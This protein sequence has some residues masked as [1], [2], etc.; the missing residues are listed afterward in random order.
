MGLSLCMNAGGGGDDVR[1]D[2][3]AFQVSCDIS[4]MDEIDEYCW[5]EFGPKDW[6]RS[7]MFYNFRNKEDSVQFR[8][9]F[10]G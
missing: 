1:D 6:F 2:W 10:A 4:K 7:G 8:L 9:M 3:Y 5:D